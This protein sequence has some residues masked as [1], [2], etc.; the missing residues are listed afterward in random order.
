MLTI[1]SLA[2]ICRAC[3]KTDI[4]QN[5][6]FCLRTTHALLEKFPTHSKGHIL[7]LICCS[8][9]THLNCCASDL[10]ISDHKLISFD[11][12]LRLSRTSMLYLLSKIDLRQIN[13]YPAIIS[14]FSDR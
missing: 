14:D 8:G 2:G 9:V 5:R 12:M 13:W 10:P 6:P 3:E 1:L 7:D 4:C 11:V